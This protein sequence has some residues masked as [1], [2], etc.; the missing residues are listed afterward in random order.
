MEHCQLNDLP[1]NLLFWGG[2]DQARVIRPIIEALGSSVVVVI[3]DTPNLSS[4]FD[5]VEIFE[6][7][8]GFKKW[9]SG[10]NPGDFG[11]VVAIGNPFGH[12][13]CRV[14]DFLI[15]E[16]MK[17]VSFSDPSAIV[18]GSAR[19]GPGAQ[20]M[21]QAVVNVDASL[22]KQCI[23]NTGAIV[24]H[25]CVL[26]A[27]VEIGPGAILNGRITV[28]NYSW[29]CSRATVAPRISIGDSSILGAGCLVLSDV[30]N[31]VTVTGVPA[32]ETKTR[33]TVPLK[34]SASMRRW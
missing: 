21:C 3:D 19:I 34:N 4:P 14:H 17:P 8:P 29:I 11:F 12:A 28:G 26:G 23:I 1:P 27:G 2:G 30:G 31:E 24:E 15:D 5:D 25:D 13:R 18:D 33:T 22:G 6:G 16:G 32:K 20:I 7:P 9:V 10:R